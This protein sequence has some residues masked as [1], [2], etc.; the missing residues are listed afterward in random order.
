MFFV[1][2][3]FVIKLKY[4]HLLH[5]MQNKRQG[6]CSTGI[7][8]EENIFLYLRHP[9]TKKKHNS[10]VPQKEKQQKDNRQ[11]QVLHLSIWQ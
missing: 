11:L 4:N 2:F 6:H 8:G 10:G 1:S 3:R 9:L 7:K 5:R